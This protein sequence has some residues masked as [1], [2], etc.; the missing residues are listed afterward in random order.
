LV[1]FARS[2]P[3]T[4]LVVESLAGRSLAAVMEIIVHGFNGVVGGVNSSTVEHAISRLATNFASFTPGVSVDT[5]R[6]AIVTGF[7]LALEVGASPDGRER[8]R[9]VVDISSSAGGAPELRDVFNFTNERGGADGAFVA[10]QGEPRLL[11]ELRARGVQIDTTP[12]QR[13]G[14]S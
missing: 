8:V 14:N 3:E 12:F 1:D 13:T 6:Q 2:L 11:D 9:R 7:D 4:N 5:A 10:A